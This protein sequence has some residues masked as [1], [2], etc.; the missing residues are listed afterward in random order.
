MYKS[1][2]D[3]SIVSV[4]REYTHVWIDPFLAQSVYRLQY[5][6]LTAMPLAMVHNYLYVLKYLEGPQ[7]H[8]AYVTYS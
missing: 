2:Y 4:H 3:P 7:L 8:A 6:R 5:K 1:V